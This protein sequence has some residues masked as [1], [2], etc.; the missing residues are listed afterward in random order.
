MSQI[1]FYVREPIQQWYLDNL[2]AAKKIL[3]GFEELNNL[4]NNF[5]GYEDKKITMNHNVVLGYTLP[6]LNEK[7]NPD[8]KKVLD[9]LNHLIGLFGIVENTNRDYRHLRSRLTKNDYN[10]SVFAFDELYLANDL[11]LK[12][13]MENVKL[14]PKLKDGTSDVLVTLGTKKIFFELTVRN[15]N[16]PERILH[17][18]SNQVAEHIG[19]QTSKNDSYLQ[20]ILDSKKL[21]RDEKEDIDEKKSL[22][23]FKNMADQLK[24]NELVGHHGYFDL[25]S[26]WLVTSFGEIFKRKNT[27]FYENHVNKFKEFNLPKEWLM[28]KNSELIQTSPFTGFDGGKS[29]GLKIIVEVRDESIFSLG[30]LEFSGIKRQI[31]GKIKSK[32]KN[33]LESGLLNI[34][35]LRGSMPYSHSFP[36]SESMTDIIKIQHA[37]TKFLEKNI[38]ENISGVIFFNRLFDEAKLIMNPH[39]EGSSK[40]DDD[41]IRQ[42]EFPIYDDN[43]EGSIWSYTDTKFS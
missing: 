5:E 10:I 32:S 4:F 26:S 30:S 7:Y 22:N 42:L 1:G 11:A 29:N 19:K 39:A 15:L 36:G 16:T 28:Q 21:I 25:N 2:D 34:L 8:Y 40:L 38:F 43:S 31:F 35:V 18:I 41:T 13:G 33:Q 12:F 20:I 14:M 9:D 3:S 6:D 17:S 27:S 24:I 37:I 23:F